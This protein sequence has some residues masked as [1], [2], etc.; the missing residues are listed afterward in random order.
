MWKLWKLL[1]AWSKITKHCK[2]HFYNSTFTTGHDTM[3]RR[4]HWDATVGNRYQSP[5]PY[6]KKHRGSFLSMSHVRPVTGSGKRAA[7]RHWA[8]ACLE[9]C[10]RGQHGCCW[11][12]SE[13]RALVEGGEIA[14]AT[15]V[16]HKQL[17]PYHLLKQLTSSQHFPNSERLPS[18]GFCSR[19]KNLRIWSYF[20]ISHWFP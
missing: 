10:S 14:L 18:T 15:A 8:A 9:G 17:L 1:V 5:V 7:W 2:Q 4:I 12:Q 3:L 6:H 19:K 13:R 20:A 11:Q 16:T